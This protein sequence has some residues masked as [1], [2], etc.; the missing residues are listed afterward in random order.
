[1]RKVRWQMPLPV[2][3]RQEY[4]ARV[5]LPAHDRWRIRAPRNRCVRGIGEIGQQRAACSG[6]RAH[7]RHPGR[8]RRRNSS[9]AIGRRGQSRPGPHA[10]QRSSLPLPAPRPTPRPAPGCL[11]R[12]AGGVAASYFSVGSRPSRGAPV[13]EEPMKILRPSVKVTSRP[14][15]RLDRSLLW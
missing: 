6:S 8:G 5:D 3:S 4:Q 2:E 14:L 7:Q 10:Q 12:I 11:Q 1:M 9:R 15:A 13:P